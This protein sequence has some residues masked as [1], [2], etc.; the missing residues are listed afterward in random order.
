MGHI[1]QLKNEGDYFAFGWREKP[2]CLKGRD[3]EARTF[4][5]VCQHRAHQWSVAEGQPAWWCASHAWTYELT[6]V[7]LGPSRNVNGFDRSDSVRPHSTKSLG[8][9]FVV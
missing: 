5:N 2:L 8:F 1:G 9:I 3:G 4:Y 6:R 7:A